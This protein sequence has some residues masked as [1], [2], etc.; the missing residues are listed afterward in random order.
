MDPSNPSS[1]SNPEADNQQID[2]SLNSPNIDNPANNHNNPNTNHNIP[3]SKLPGSRAKLITTISIVVGVAILAVGIVV[4]ANI[5]LDNIKEGSSADNAQEELVV[6]SSN[7]VERLSFYQNELSRQYRDYQVNSD[8]VSRLDVYSETYGIFAPVEAPSDW[9]FSFRDG[10]HSSE[11][12]A[13]YE[14]LVSLLVSDGF[15]EFSGTT[16]TIVNEFNPEDTRS[17]LVSNDI[18][19][20]INFDEWAV[21]ANC[22]IPGKADAATEEVAPF[23]LAYYKV[24]SL[25]DID[26]ETRHNTALWIHEIKTTEKFPEY[27]VAKGG[28]IL[29]GWS[30][31]LSYYRMNQGNWVFTYGGPSVPSCDLGDPDAHKAYYDDYCDATTFGE[32]HNL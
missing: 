4:F 12:H 15:S 31:Q 14:T 19:C 26:E 8:I 13:P 3:P 5:L 17:L 23:Y 2:S 1:N 29:S 27:E 16:I 9:S 11:H 21:Y 18:L 25:M 7:I 28:G 20:K 22:V 10:R 32:Y 6:D 24:D 30:V